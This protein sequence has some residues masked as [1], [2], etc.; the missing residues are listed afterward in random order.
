MFSFLRLRKDSKKSTSESREAD[1]GF[2]IIGETVEEQRRKMQSMNIAQPS[3]NVIVLPSKSPYPAPALPVETILSTDPSPTHL[4]D[5]SS[6]VED[7]FS[8]VE[9]SSPAPDVLGDIP[10][11]LAPHVQA[12]QRGFCYIPD[13]LLSKDMNSNLMYFQ[14]DFTLEKSV[15][16]FTVP[17]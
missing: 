3:T 4:G 10:F 2:V 16:H 14:Y 11:A 7:G 5:R 6:V 13:V 17:N 12:M 15:L 9:A 1:G 8:V